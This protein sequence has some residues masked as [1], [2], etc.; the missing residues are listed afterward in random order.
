MQDHLLYVISAVIVLGSL[1]Q[2]LSWWLKLLSILAL[3]V[4]GIVADSLTGALL[5]VLVYQYIV[6]GA[7]PYVLLF[8]SI[9][10]G[11]LAGVA[12]S[13]EPGI[14]YPQA[15]DAGKSLKRGALVV[16]DNGICLQQLPGP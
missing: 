2:W 1:A 5:A 10:V 4:V 9:G 7:E 16:G 6:A 14:P 15:L 11:L 12:G 13:T 3:L 8:E